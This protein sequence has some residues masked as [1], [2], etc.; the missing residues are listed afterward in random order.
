MPVAAEKLFHAALVSP[1]AQFL[2]T[3][4]TSVQ[5]PAHDGSVGLLTHRAPL[6]TRLGIGVLTMQSVDG[7]RRFVIA[8]GYAQ[9]HENTLTIL[10]E[11]AL[12]AGEVTAER[13]ADERARLAELTGT[14]RASMERR[15]KQ[16]ARIAAM[17]QL[18]G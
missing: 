5:V 11:E 4:V 12:A 18:L 1:E 3:Q 15:Q 17:Q 10:A 2:D 13:L 8:G 9:M 16:Q 14:D 7:P 6:V